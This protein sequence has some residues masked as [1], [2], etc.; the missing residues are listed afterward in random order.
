ML[1]YLNKTDD[2]NMAYY[3]KTDDLIPLN[4]ILHFL[5]PAVEIYSKFSTLAP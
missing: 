5:T 3:G 1:T 4:G 2:L